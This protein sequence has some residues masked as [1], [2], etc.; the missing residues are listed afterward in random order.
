MPSPAVLSVGRKYFAR[1]HLNSRLLCP[2]MSS[3]TSCPLSPPTLLKHGDSAWSW[4]GPEA[5]A[6][7]WRKAAL[8]TILRL[9]AIV[10]K[11]GATGVPTS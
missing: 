1:G 10:V 3:P 2:Q 8:V 6:N 7:L 9:S 4:T 11:V 5:V